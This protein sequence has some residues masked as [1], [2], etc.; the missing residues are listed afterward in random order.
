MTRLVAAH[1]HSTP[2]RGCWNA[3]LSRSLSDRSMLPDGLILA[4]V[5]GL[6]ILRRPT[7]VRGRVAAVVVPAIDRMIPRWATTHIRNEVLERPAPPVADRDP[8]SAISV[9]GTDV[10]VVATGTHGTPDGVFRRLSHAVRPVIEWARLK[11]QAPTRF[12]LALL[13]I[14]GVHKP[15]RPA[16]APAR[17][18][19]TASVS[20]HGPS[21]EAF[22]RREARAGHTSIIPR[23]FAVAHDLVGEP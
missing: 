18:L 13:E 23:V 8:S 4:G 7:T 6:L 11:R 21:V 20:Q 3:C 5:G 1:D 15:E 22:S 19:A 17:P 2:E 10:G 14:V 12:V 16:I 9:E